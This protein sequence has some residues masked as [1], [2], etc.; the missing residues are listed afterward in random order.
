MFAA[1]I[2]NSSDFIGIADANGKPTYL[3]PAGRRMVGSPPIIRIEDTQ[4]PDYY[5]PDQRSFAPDVIVKSMVEK[6][7]W[8]GETYFRNWQTEEAIPVS[9]KHFMIRDPETGQ[10]P[11][12]GHH[13]PRHLGSPRKVQDELRRTNEELVEAREFLENVLESSTEY[14]IIAKDLERRILV[15]NKGAARIY[16]YDASEVIGR[17]SDMLH[18][19]EDS[20]Q[21]WLPSSTERALAEGHADGLFRRR[22]KD[23]SEFLARV[24]ITRRNDASGNAIGYLLV[25]HDV[26]AEQRHVEEQQFLAEVGEA[27]QASLDYAATVERI[28]RLVV[29]FMGDCCAI[30]VVAGRRTRQANESRPRR[31]GES[32]HSPRPRAHPARPHAP[33]PSGESWRRGSR[34]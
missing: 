23:G 13:H 21:A 8:Q 31:P 26:T 22:R 12:N 32:G 16:G 9:D 30:D 34:C 10:S 24:M 11:R 19:P 5:P 29:G 28:A 27:L 15:W 6:G 18:V 25:S 2:E 20:G 1:L 7:H 17:S 4:I 14:S 3:N 33:I